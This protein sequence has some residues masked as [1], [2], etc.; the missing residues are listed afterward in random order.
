MS[1]CSTNA[2]KQK[3]MPVEPMCSCD[4]SRRFDDLAE[5]AKDIGDWLFMCVETDPGHVIVESDQ[6]DAREFR[7]RLE[8]LGVSTNDVG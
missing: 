3:T 1:D 8:A 6:A 4:R 7:E 5:V 2:M